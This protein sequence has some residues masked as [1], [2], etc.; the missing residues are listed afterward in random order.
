MNRDALRPF[1]HAVL[2]VFHSPALS[3]LNHRL[4]WAMRAARWMHQNPMP[5]LPNRYMLYDRAIEKY[6]LA[7]TPITYLEF[8]V[9][10]GAS[11]KYWVE[12]NHHPD[13]QFRGFDTF[14][15]LPERWGHRDTGTFSTEGRT[16]AIDDPRCAFEV[17]FVQQT[18][19]AALEKVNLERQLVVHYDLDLYGP[20]LFTLIHLHRYMKPGDLI[21][22]DELVTI[23]ADTHE[24]RA[25]NDYLE[26][27]HSAI[28]LKPVATSRHGA[29]TCL[30]VQ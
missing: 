10:K 22:F 29:N 30:E 20:T 19:S 24:F 6:N 16:P 28:K 17:G 8:G 3:D 4:L 25:L 13:S 18:L 5:Q 7:E 1:V 23:N 21:L 11:I 2:N 15:G 12:K 9:F 26:A 27:V 14:V